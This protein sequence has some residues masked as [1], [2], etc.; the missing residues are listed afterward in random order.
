M[1]GSTTNGTFTG[2][3]GTF[4]LTV[5]SDVSLVVSYVGYL[6]QEVVVGS[7]TIF[8]IALVPSITSLSEVVVTGY[9]FE[10]KNDITGS[11][12]IVDMKALKSIPSGSAM[13]ALKGQVPGITI[14]HS[15]APGSPSNIFIRGISSFGNTQPLVL[16]DGIQ[17]ELNDVSATDIES[18]QVLKDAGAAA[19]YGVCGSNGVIIVTTKKR[20][21]G[22]PT[23]P[24]DAYYGSQQPLQGNVFDLMNS[25]DFAR[26]F[27]SAGLFIQRKVSTGGD[28]TPGWFFPL[29]IATSVRHV[30]V[31]VGWL[32]RKG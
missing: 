28:R 14:L 2:A 29:W 10:K 12:S 18:V 4:T 11:V 23:I 30:S 16:I 9:S 5:P 21:F 1:K 22:Q 3:D 24:Y 8:S 7:K 31:G 32:A 20:R 13:Q 25:S 19:I 26:L 17:A 6:A 27:R 15:G